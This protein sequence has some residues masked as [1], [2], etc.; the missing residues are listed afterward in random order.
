[1][2]LYFF[3]FLSMIYHLFFFFFSSRRRHTICGRDWS[4]DV[5]SSDLPDFALQS[6]ITYG[7]SGP[8]MWTLACVAALASLLFVSSPRIAELLLLPGLFLLFIALPYSAIQ[9]LGLERDGRFDQ[10]RL[11][12]RPPLALG[13]AVLAGS[14]WP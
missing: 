4:S 8:Y 5:C 12:G 11:A 6:R 9:I 13:L 3:I 7:R 2:I 14:S 10:H 1:M